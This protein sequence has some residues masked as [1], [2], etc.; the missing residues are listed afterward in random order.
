MI[1][2]HNPANPAIASRK[3]TDL[4]VGLRLAILR[5]IFKMLTPNIYFVFIPLD[6]SS[7]G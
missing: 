3:P 4:S 5:E 6:I 2:Q 1:G 7:L